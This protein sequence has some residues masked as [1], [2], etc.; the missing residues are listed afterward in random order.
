[1]PRKRIPDLPSSIQPIASNFYTVVANDV[2]TYKSEIRDLPLSDNMVFNN[3]SEI[4]RSLRDR[5]SDVI[6][7]KDFGAKG[8][9]SVIDT[10]Y[11]NNAAEAAAGRTLFFPKGD[12]YIDGTITLYPNTRVEGSGARIIQTNNNTPLFHAESNTVTDFI[13]IYNLSLEG[14]GDLD[15]AKTQRIYS[16]TGEAEAYGVW[17]RSIKNI[18]IKDCRFYNFRNAA[19]M[20]E[21]GKVVS[22]LNNHVIGTN[23]GDRDLGISAGST[24]YVQ[25]GICIKS[26]DVL[27][28][29]WE[30]SVKIDQNIISYTGIGI[31]VDRNYKNTTITNN[32]IADISTDG[33]SVSPSDRLRITHNSVRATNYGI[34]VVDD[35]TTGL[36]VPTNL[37]VSHNKIYETHSAGI[38]FNTGDAIANSEQIYHSARYTRDVSVTDNLIESYNGSGI[39]LSFTR[40]TSI[41]N[42]SIR[43][44]QLIGISI[45]DGSGSITN[46]F[47]SNVD[48]TGITV[49]PTI[50]ELCIVDSNFITESCANAPFGYIDAFF[51]P[52]AAPRPTRISIWFPGLD[53]L[54]GSIVQTLKDG[55]SRVYKSLTSGRSIGNSAGGPSGTGQSIL[56]NN[57]TW[58]YI[59]DFETVD[60]GEVHILNNVVTASIDGLV[61]SDGIVTTK[62]FNFPNLYSIFVEK[63]G[64]LRWCDNIVPSFTRER[65][66]GSVER[67]ALIPLKVYIIATVLNEKN[68][69]HGGYEG[70]DTFTINYDSYA[71]G[72]PARE[73]IGDKSP[74]IGSWDVAD[75]IWNTNLNTNPYLGWVCVSGGSPGLWEQF[76]YVGD[77]ATTILLPPS[78]VDSLNHEVV[79]GRDTRLSNRRTPLSH[80]STHGSTG[81]DPITPQSIGALKSSNNLTDIANVEQ[82]RINLGLG[83]LSKYNIPLSPENGQLLTFSTSTSALMWTNPTG[84]VQTNKFTLDVGDGVLT[85]YTVVHNLDNSDVIV[86]V[87][88]KNSYNQNTRD[89]ISHT[90]TINDS[91]TITVT[92]LDIIDRDQCR[93]IVMS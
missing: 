79:L 27:I 74:I 32:I 39:L 50:S 87:Y 73:F 10:M 15:T 77:S 36:D 26:D 43:N 11:I 65:I 19:I 64:R 46:N 92:F 29:E 59:G 63:G 56:D 72:S 33:I 90:V 71:Q 80:S 52:T 66:Q 17:S 44:V 48:G 75:K 49:T 34:E 84:T 28:S 76:G 42:N 88:S 5:F 3:G 8:V 83:T 58:S 2:S 9:D 12:Y 82:A 60:Q 23:E 78:G 70:L 68:N 61:Q 31:R 30:Q 25:Y 85:S 54:E 13:E 24:G 89:P 51:G 45:V 41:T 16:G 37:V 91:N 67:G 93:V 38:V 35:A 86:Q 69:K 21:S 22:V 40:N 62:K 20:I 81:T 47:L 1:M 57:I 6:N 55:K 53:Y 4:S 18:T 7:V 14:V